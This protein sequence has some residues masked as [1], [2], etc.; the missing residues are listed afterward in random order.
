MKLRA[1]F[2]QWAVSWRLSRAVV[3]L[4]A[5]STL[6]ALVLLFAGFCEAHIGVAASLNPACSTLWAGLD[7]LGAGHG[8]LHC[9]GQPSRPVGKAAAFTAAIPLRGVLQARYAGRSGNQLLQHFA[10]RFIA[11]RL[12]WALLIPAGP[13]G[14][15]GEPG[16]QALA[17]EGGEAVERRG[18]FA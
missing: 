3:A 15:F 8:P 10:L 11:A 13:L 1:G 4:C 2:C 6:W 16:L 9:P 14:E 12:G 17:A 5:V 7:A 18:E